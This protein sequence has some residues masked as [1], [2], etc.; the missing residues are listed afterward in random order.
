MR[1]FLSLIILF[2]LLVGTTGPALAQDTT[3]TDEPPPGSQ[4]FLPIV[5]ADTTA[6]TSADESLP[7]APAEVV[8]AAKGKGQGQGQGQ[9]N[10]NGQGNCND[11]GNGNG[12]GCNKPNQAD[13]Q[14][15]A[16]RSLQQGALNP[17]MLQAQVA[18]LI[19]G[20]PH[21]FSHPNYANSPLPTIEGAVISVGSPL[22]DRAWASDT[23]VA[24]GE[25]APVMVLMG[26]ALPDGM[27]QS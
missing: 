6:T 11:N 15:A 17:L 18:N 21:Y 23:A 12:N 16:A 27:I 9:A 3:S 24:V 5:T 2:S 7:P 13:R 14:A 4:V 1:R 10:G 22:Q 8:A 26:E 25:L 20:A 19:D